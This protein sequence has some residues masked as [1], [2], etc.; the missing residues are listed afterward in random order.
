MSALLFCQPPAPTAK[1][2]TGS[3]V[4]PVVASHDRKS[5]GLEANDEP[6]L[7]ERQAETV[8]IDDDPL[9][10]MQWVRAFNRRV[11]GQSRRLMMESIIL[12]ARIGLC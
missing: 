12:L 3:R 4:R 11:I 10:R 5:A 8:W 9:A 2:A 6:G 7:G 1:T